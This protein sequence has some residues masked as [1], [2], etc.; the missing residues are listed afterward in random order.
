VN[1][2]VK[3]GKEYRRA[4]QASTPIRDCV[5]LIRFDDAEGVA[6]Y[7]GLTPSGN[8]VNNPDSAKMQ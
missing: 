1:E 6:P 4:K 5:W 3:S 7:T 8:A 2:R